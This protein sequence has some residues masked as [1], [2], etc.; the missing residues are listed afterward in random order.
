VKRR[1]E[2][3]KKNLGLELFSQN[4][5]HDQHCH[6]E[7]QL[8]REELRKKWKLQAE[9]R[10]AMTSEEAQLDFLRAQRKLK[11]QVEDIREEADWHK[12]HF[13][14][15]CEKTARW[16]K[17]ELENDLRKMVMKGWRKDMWKTQWGQ[18]EPERFKQMMKEGP[19]D[20][21]W[22]LKRHG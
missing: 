15:L 6:E 5:K 1:A 11:K 7:I 16:T 3:N 12:R 22:I 4:K 14:Q 13:R 10:M 20:K 8:Q 21:P 2:S 18:L 9:H 17:E 19:L